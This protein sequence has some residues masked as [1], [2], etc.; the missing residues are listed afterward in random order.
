VRRPFRAVLAACAL[1]LVLAP[2]G[3][4]ATVSG[5]A[6]P[7]GQPP[8]DDGAGGGAGP[9]GAPLDA[10]TLLGTPV[11]SA[12]TSGVG[13]SVCGWEDPDYYSITVSVGSPG[14][15]PDDRLD[16]SSA[17]GDTEPV[18]SLGPNGRYA[19]LGIVEFTAGDRLNSVQVVLRD[20][21]RGRDEAERLAGLLRDRIG[22]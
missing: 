20:P 6:T 22:R 17:F 19:G 16:P 5:S 1:V 12:P 13:E 11:E 2:A 15:A 18:P 3:C 21:A 7:A 14:T 4:A 10:C 8:G 9:A